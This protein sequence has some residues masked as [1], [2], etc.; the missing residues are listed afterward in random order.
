MATPPRRANAAKI[1]STSRTF[2]VTSSTWDKRN[3]LQSDRCAALFIKILYEYR[4]QGKFKLHE[5]VV[6]PDHFHLLLTVGNEMPI[7][8]AVQFIKGGFAFRA[9]KEFGMRAPFW[10]KGFSEV[11]VLEASGYARM[12]EYI[13]NNPVKR[14]LVRQAEEYLYSSART[15]IEL[16]PQP[17]GPKPV[18]IGDLCDR[19][20]ALS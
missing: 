9:G 8:R 12:R 20:E 3:L 14:G 16:D 13:R 6:M 2:F 1:I 17:Q 18:K 19:A 10:Q 11:R 15:G 5:F 7:E 4:V